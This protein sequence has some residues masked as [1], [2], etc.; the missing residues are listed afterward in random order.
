MS[1]GAASLR[2]MS[3]ALNC[4][5]DRPFV[6]NMP[7]TGRDFIGRRSDCVALSS[8]ISH[9]SNVALWGPPKCGK[10]SAIRQALLDV[11]QSGSSFL[12]CEL[13]LADVREPHRFAR[14]LAGRLLQTAASVPD[15]IAGLGGACLGGTSLAFDPEAYSDTG[16]V[17]PGSFPLPEDEL[18]EVLELPYRLADML[19]KGVAVILREFQSL[20][21]EAGERLFALMAEVFAAHREQSGHP[22]SYVMTGSRPNAMEDIFVRRRYFRD[23][24]ERH[25]LSPIPEAA[26]SEHVLRGFSAGGKVIDRDLLSGVCRLL[27][28][29]IWYINQFF[30]ICDS[31]SKGF[32]SE[33]ILNDALACLIALHEPRF[34]AMLG[35]LTDFQRRLLGAVLDGYAK[36]STT[37]VIEKYALNSSANVKRLKD[38]LM[39]K[40]V[41]TFDDK[42]EPRILDPLFEYWL[43]KICI[44]D[45]FATF[46]AAGFG[47][48][49]PLR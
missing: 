38:A 8:L 17:F 49:A 36:F 6:F 41:I 13:D 5:M 22:C 34:R 4:K 24:V 30:F 33:I 18:R 19:G 10:M 28:G 26:L 3:I 1:G 7:V 2:G 39:K 29:N 44:P 37:E 27:K 46:A 43:K 14:R 15:E 11:H 42:D 20:D 45:N 31:L 40:E 25:Q 12:A 35:D 21:S 16:E 32:I 9:G 23:T 47:S 48:D